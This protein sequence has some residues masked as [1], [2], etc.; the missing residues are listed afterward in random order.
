MVDVA[1]KTVL[2]TGAGGFIGSH[3]AESLV[4]K[5]ANVRALVHYNSLGKKGWLDVSP[6]LNDLEVIAGDIRDSD[7]CH[8]ICEKVDVVFNLAALIAIPYSY[9]APKSYLDT[10]ISGTLNLSLAALNKGCNLFVHM[11]TS[12]VYGTA[13][14]VPIDENHPLQPQSP[15][16][17]S[18]IGAESMV[19][20]LYKSFDLPVIIP[21]V[22]N[23]YGPRQSMRAIIPNII[24][25]ALNG[26]KIKLG[27][28]TPTRDFSFIGTTC[29]RLIALASTK[30]C[31]GEIINLGSGQEIS[32]GELVPIISTI[33]NINLEVS[34]EAER[35]RPV[36][37]EVNRLLAD[38]T[39][40]KD[41]VGKE[42]IHDLK[43]GLSE[44]VDWFSN[45]RH[46]F[47]NSKNEIQL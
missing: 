29:E 24:I 20:S 42:I 35:L 43:L 22:F 21:R 15:Y 30:N 14:H 16:S 37:S 26:P 28:L 12:E 34:G 11:S 32:V 3:L 8:K 6:Y 10:N 25:Q 44:T 41:M 4:K 17:A 5:G 38:T 36:K 7:C 33:M 9:I 46:V 23:T 47:E 40:Y 27:N 39:K 19:M 45:N 2:V 31:I 1:G 18:K 13:L